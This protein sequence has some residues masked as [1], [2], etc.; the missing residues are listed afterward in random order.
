MGRH[1]TDIRWTNELESP[2]HCPRSSPG[3]CRFE[4]IFYAVDRIVLE[5]SDCSRN[6]VLKSSFLSFPGE[7]LILLHTGHFL[8]VQA[9]EP[10]RDIC[11]PVRG[12]LSI[13]CQGNSALLL[14]ACR[15][16]PTVTHCPFGQPP[17]TYFSTSGSNVKLLG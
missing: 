11:V 9:R 13:R 14:K 8:R 5:H 12:L 15:D 4:G 1:H 10:S 16:P 7:M 3:L 6:N 17:T 2:P